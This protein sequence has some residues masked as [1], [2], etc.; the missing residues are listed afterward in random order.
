MRPLCGVLLIIAGIILLDWLAWG[1]EDQ[2]LALRGTAPEGGLGVNLFTP[3]AS[4]TLERGGGPAITRTAPHSRISGALPGG[5]GLTTLRLVPWQDTCTTTRCLIPGMNFEI[6]R[7][8]GYKLAPRF[9]GREETAGGDF[10]SKLLLEF[11]KPTVK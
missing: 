11:T 3:D 9:S 2:F 5:G 6:E 4:G 8:G 10:L 7:K 1:G